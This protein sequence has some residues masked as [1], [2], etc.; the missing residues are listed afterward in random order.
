MEKTSIPCQ[1]LMNVK[2]IPEIAAEIA[3]GM[4][5]ISQ[6][7]ETLIYSNKVKKFNRFALTQER[8]MIITDRRILNSKKQSNFY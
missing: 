7:L 4:N 5:I 1:D 2:A 3:K 8:V 6:I